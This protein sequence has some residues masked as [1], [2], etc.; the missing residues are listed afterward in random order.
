MDFDFQEFKNMTKTHVIN[1][2]LIAIL[3]YSGIEYELVI[4]DNATNVIGEIYGVDARD[5]YHEIINSD[6]DKAL[7][8]INKYL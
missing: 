3:S 1:N 7:E 8:T 2:D 4:E 5:C 6:E